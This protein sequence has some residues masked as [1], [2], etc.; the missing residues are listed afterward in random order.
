MNRPTRRGPQI[1]GKIRLD[2]A[3]VERGFVDSRA[4]AQASIL[5]GEVY[6]DTVRADKPGL[7]V[8]ADAHIEI[9]TRRPAFVSRGGEKLDHALAAFAIDVSGLVAVDAGASTG[10]FTDCLLQ[11]GARQVYAIDVGTGQLDWRLRQDLRVVSLEQRDIRGV[12]PEDLQEPVDLATV[13]V[14]FIS[15]SK[16]LPSVARLVRPGG[17][18]VVLVKPQFEVGPKLAR[19]GVVRDAAVHR[20]VL[21]TI[22]AAATRLRLSPIAATPSPIAG[23]DGNL[24]FFLHLRNT[25]DRATPIDVDAVVT[26]AHATVKRSPA[27]G[28]A[29]RGQIHG[30][31]PVSR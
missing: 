7:R 31:V 20:E 6:V 24:E 8:P 26:T 27:S 16:V 14:A 21:A 22:I 1:S 12:T 5:A 2:V 28:A 10:G 19:R 23:P 13:D 4:R 30:P 3:L 29:G 11:H 9:R 25:P 17:S 18:I 15:L